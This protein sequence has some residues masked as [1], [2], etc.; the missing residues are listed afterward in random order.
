[1]IIP[2]PT[3][4]ANTDPPDAIR[5]SCGNEWPWSW[6]VPRVNGKTYTG[7]WAAPKVSPCGLCEV[8][9]TTL[10]ERALYGRLLAAGIPEPLIGHALERDLLT[11]QRPGEGV[12]GF[13]ARVAAARQKSPVLGVAIDQ[14]AAYKAVVG[15]RPPQWLVLHGP[16]GT[17]KT[18]LL[19]GLARRLLR[20]AE[21]R[22]ETRD[23]YDYVVRTPHRHVEYHR[24]DE[25]LGRE[26]VK[27]R[28]LDD[29]PT[30][31][32][33]RVGLRTV[34]DGER[35]VQTYDRNAVLMLDELGLDPSPREAERRLV[36]RILCY[37]HDHGLCTVI[38][39]NR[40]LDE[41]VGPESVYGQRVGDR[42]RTA[43]AVA[44]TGDSWRA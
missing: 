24:V 10:A 4:A 13:R 12:E 35:S 7:R 43:L 2:L 17:G 27:L 18:T 6:Y 14:V 3:P 9:A 41:I 38:A 39:T 22:R 33:A 28:G 21:E 34:S 16:P 44:L 20:H 23:G 36:E 29:S 30:R 1:M 15:W 37:R 8:P 26:A 32:V 31:D 40:D 42:L 19:A 5:C 11:Q 25:V